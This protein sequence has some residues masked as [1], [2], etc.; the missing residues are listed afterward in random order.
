L[1]FQPP[2]KSPFCNL[3]SGLINEALMWIKSAPWFGEKTGEISVLG[4]TPEL[5]S[6]RGATL[7]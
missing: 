3:G 1:T 5:A 7:R 6:P 2:G 4:A